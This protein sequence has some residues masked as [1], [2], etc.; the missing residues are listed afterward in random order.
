M[1]QLFTVHCAYAR[2]IYLQ[3]RKRG[4]NFYHIISYAMVEHIA[5]TQNALTV[6]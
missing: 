4:K 3:N 5:Q 2:F 6:R 1:L